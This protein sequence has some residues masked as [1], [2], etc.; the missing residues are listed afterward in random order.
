MQSRFTS[1]RGTH[2]RSCLAGAIRFQA[3]PSSSR[4]TP[5]VTRVKEATR[6][7][8]AMG[9]TESTDNIGTAGTIE[10]RQSPRI[11]LSAKL[12]VV[13]RDSA[14]TAETHVIGDYGLGGFRLKSDRVVPVGRIGR[15]IHILPERVGVDV[16]VLVVW[17]VTKPDG[18]SEFGVRFLQS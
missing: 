9:T 3:A 10:R 14:G 7:T 5:G 18:G 11:A 15:A 4:E 12:V 2:R 8:G 17:S 13:W 1:A 6:G 16:D